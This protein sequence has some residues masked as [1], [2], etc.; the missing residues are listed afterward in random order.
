VIAIVG[1][2][3]S[4]KTTLSEL[5]AE[6][7]GLSVL[8]TDDF[9]KLPWDKAADAALAAISGHGIVE[10]ITVA[11]LFRRGFKPDLVIHLTGGRQLPSMESLI[12]RGLSEYTG[13]TIHIKGHHE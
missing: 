8:H 3:R 12:K 6:S 5:I 9:R 4:G 13:T 1:L 11:R 10:G 7:V 2:P